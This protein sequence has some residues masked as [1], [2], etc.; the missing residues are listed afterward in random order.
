MKLAAIK[1]GGK[2]YLVSE[3]QELKVE[4]LAYNKGDKFVFDQI[5]ML[6]DENGDD[7]KVG[8]PYIKDAKVEAKILE[9]GRDK[10][11]RV[12]KYKSKIRYHKVHG[13][14]QPFT[15]VKINKIIKEGSKFDENEETIKSFAA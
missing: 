12:T 4:K 7:L 3:G 2:Q 10:K 8:D 6:S 15:K 9:Q 11:I 14:R 13:H 5:L 1:T